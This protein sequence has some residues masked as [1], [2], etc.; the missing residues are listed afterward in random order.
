MGSEATS[1]GQQ[2]RGITKANASELGKRGAAARAAN[3]RLAEED[4]IAYANL[5][6]TENRARLVT[7]LLSAALGRGDWKDLPLDK[8]LQALIKA[9]EYAQGKPVT[10]RAASEGDEEEVPRRGISVE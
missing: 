5:R 7:E 6:L 8:R 1:D 9:L 4:P 10:G 2:E 3:R